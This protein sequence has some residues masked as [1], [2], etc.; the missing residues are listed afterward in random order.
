MTPKLGD[1]HDDGVGHILQWT[2]TE[3]TPVCPKCDK[4]MLV[5]NDKGRLSCGICGLLAMDARRPS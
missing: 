4:P 5:Y 3:L 2:G 1:R